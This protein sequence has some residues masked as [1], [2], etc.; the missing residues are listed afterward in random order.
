MQLGGEGE[1]R[2]HGDFAGPELGEFGLD[3]SV[4]RSVDFERMLLAEAH[5]GRVESSVPVFVAPA[6]GANAD[7][8]RHKEDFREALRSDL[9]TGDT[10]EHRGSPR[11]Y[12][13]LK[14]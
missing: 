12:A 6:G 9:T 5:A 7:A 3:V 1:F 13:D 14:E 4:E 8:R 2:I 10:E 11:I